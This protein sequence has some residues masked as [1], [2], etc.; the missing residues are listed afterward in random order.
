MICRRIFLAIV[1]AVFT[2]LSSVAQAEVLYEQT[3]FNPGGGDLAFSTYGWSLD[4]PGWYSGSYSGSYANATGGLRDAATNA[5]INGNSA[6]F[7]G[8]GGP[9]TASLGMFY[10]TEGSGGLNDPID[11]SQCERCYLSIYSQPGPNGAADDLAYFAVKVRDALNDEAPPAWYIAT[12]PMAP[13]TAADPLFDLRRLEFHT[14]SWDNFAVDET[15]AVAPVRGSTVGQLSGVVITGVGV[16]SSLTNP[17]GDFSGLNYAD[18]RILCV[19]EPASLV[20]V[21][22]AMGFLLSSRRKMS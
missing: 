12:D 8:S 21:A 1:M 15:G 4:A 11:P 20:L 2:A 6:V 13:P 17:S 16:V 5:P 19:P 7:L 3:F 10:T 18:Y 9:I 14:A 22:C